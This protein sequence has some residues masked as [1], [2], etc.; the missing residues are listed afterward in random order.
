[1][2]GAERLI[3]RGSELADGGTGIRFELPGQPQPVS[4]FVVRHAGRVYAYV[5]RCP[6][7][8][9]ELDWDVG[10]FFDGTGSLLI[11]SNHGATFL[12]D[13]GECIGGP[14]RGKRLASLGV[15]ERDGMVYVKETSDA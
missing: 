6:H 7:A 15:E 14:C 11:C 8:P 5:N 1:M 2:A 4:G 3:C 10:R 9:T 13:T 12:P